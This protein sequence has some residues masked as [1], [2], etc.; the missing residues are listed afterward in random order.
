MCVAPSSLAREA[1]RAAAAPRRARAQA[2]VAVAV[3]AAVVVVRRAGGRGAPGGERGVA[4][5]PPHGEGGEVELNEQL[6]HAEVA[7]AEASARAL[8][9]RALSCRH[10]SLSPP[11]LRVRRAVLSE[12]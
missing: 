7:L 10:W 1:I 4:R 2:S 6:R 9:S 3:A 5:G 11:R 8:S 12:T